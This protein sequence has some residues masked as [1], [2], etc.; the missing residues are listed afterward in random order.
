MKGKSLSL[1]FALLVWAT[2]IS[3][4]FAFPSPSAVQSKNEPP[5]GQHAHL[6]SVRLVPQDATLWGAKAS[7][8]FLVLGKFADGLERD[9]TSQCRFSVSHP[10]L[11][12]VDASGRVTALALGETA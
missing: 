10:Q 6:L 1:I 12:Q 11:A 8:H 5:S 7:Q 3:S 4:G 2:C 9:V